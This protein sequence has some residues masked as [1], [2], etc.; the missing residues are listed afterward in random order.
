MKASNA[1]VG[2]LATS[3]RSRAFL[4]VRISSTDAVEVGEAQA[5]EVAL[6]LGRR[7]GARAR[8][9][10]ANVE[11]PQLECGGKRP[12][13]TLGDSSCDC[14][15]SI[16]LGTGPTDRLRESQPSESIDCSWAR[17]RSSNSPSDVFHLPYQLPYGTR[18]IIECSRK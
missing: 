14:E 3:S 1:G 15:A 5:R 18:L 6:D 13:L 11:P 7:A 4:I 9:D 12:W 2:R 8:R 16:G 10:D 17:D